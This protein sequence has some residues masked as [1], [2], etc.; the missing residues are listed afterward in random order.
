MF[1]DAVRELVVGQPGGEGTDAICRRMVGVADSGS[2]GMTWLPGHRSRCPRWLTRQPVA[3][4][5][6]DQRSLP[7][8]VLVV[9]LEPVDVEGVARLLVQSRMTVTLWVFVI[10]RFEIGIAAVM[11]L[12]T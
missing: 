9:Q 1:A 2:S 7:D 11:P 12:P 3:P 6:A 5:L 10:W 8:G 4:V